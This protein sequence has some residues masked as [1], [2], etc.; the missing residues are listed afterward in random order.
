MEAVLQ[1][2]WRRKTLKKLTCLALGLVTAIIFSACGSNYNEM[3]NSARQ[4]DQSVTDSTMTND[5]RKAEPSGTDNEQV[6]LP[7]N[8]D[9]GVLYTTVTRGNTKELLYTSRETIEAVKN[10]KPFPSGT[11]FSLEIYRDG[12]LSDIFVSEKRIWVG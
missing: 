10:G 7:E 6:Q 4:V 1:Q 9:K 5:A 12:K 3:T 8:Y 11:V 2:L